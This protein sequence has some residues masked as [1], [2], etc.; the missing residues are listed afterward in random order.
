MKNVKA[1]TESARTPSKDKW[2]HYSRSELVD[3]SV[4]SGEAIPS[5]CGVFFVAEKPP[6]TKP[7]CPDCE[8][9]IHAHTERTTT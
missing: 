3:K 8:R 4:E 9:I 7:V 2:A 1:K 6:A 5:I